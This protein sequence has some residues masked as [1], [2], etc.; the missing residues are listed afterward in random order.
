MYEVSILNLVVSFIA[1][2]A[3]II[4]L[5]VDSYSLRCLFKANPE[6]RAGFRFEGQVMEK[7]VEEENSTWSVSRSF[8]PVN[9]SL[10]GKYTCTIK[11]SSSWLNL[12]T[13]VVRG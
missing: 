8:T 6:P 2:T 7:P 4:R 12:E 10:G 3:P 9:A 5:P 1:F 11:F 13:I